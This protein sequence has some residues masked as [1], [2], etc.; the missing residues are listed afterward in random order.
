MKCISSEYIKSEFNRKQ[1]NVSKKK[2]SILHV[3]LV[4]AYMSTNLAENV[5]ICL[6]KLSIRKINSMSDS[7]TVLH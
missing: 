4:V 6:N 3:E 7:T 1:I 2:L 5:K